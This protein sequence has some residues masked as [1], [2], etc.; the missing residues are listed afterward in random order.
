[1]AVARIKGI[2]AVRTMSSVKLQ[3]MPRVKSSAYLNLYV[4]TKEKERLTQEFAVLSQRHEQI[5]KRLNDIN[6]DISRLLETAQ[7]VVKETPMGKTTA[8]KKWNKMTLT[9]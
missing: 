9:Y 7:T 5:K 2:S 1:M 4:L 8:T 3:V 6:G